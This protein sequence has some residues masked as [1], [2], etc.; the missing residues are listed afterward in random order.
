M[1]SVTLVRLDKAV[2][3]N[4]MPFGRDT[5]VIP[6]DIVLDRGSILPRKE[7]IRCR[8]PKLAVMPPIFKLLWPLFVVLLV[9]N[10]NYP[11]RCLVSDGIMS[12][13]VTLCVS[14]EPPLISRIESTPH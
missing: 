11:R 8:N 6:S 2:G 3:R 5:R 12:L 9:E 14:A 7:V 4:E 13:G 10:I 1:S